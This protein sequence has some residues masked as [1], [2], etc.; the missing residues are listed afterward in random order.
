ML[1]S[2]KGIISDVLM[3][4]LVSYYENKF[5]IADVEVTTPEVVTKPEIIANRANNAV[6][7]LDQEVFDL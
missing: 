2:Q 1:N 7:D 3:M 6:N 4:K 5:K